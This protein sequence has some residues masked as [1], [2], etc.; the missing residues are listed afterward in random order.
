MND[1]VAKIKR[2]QSSKAQKITFYDSLGENN[3]SLNIFKL[4]ICFLIFI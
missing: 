4:L 1:Y 2:L 3:C